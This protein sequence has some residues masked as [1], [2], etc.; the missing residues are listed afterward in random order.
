MHR[1]DA[2][3]AARRFDTGAAPSYGLPCLTGAAGLEENDMAAHKS[4]EQVHAKLGHPVIDG[5][6]HWLEYTPVFAEKIRKAVGDKGAEV[7]RTTS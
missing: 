7:G 6:G 1:R 2:G 3:D 5:D 4:P